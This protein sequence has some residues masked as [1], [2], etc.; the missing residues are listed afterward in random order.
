MATFNLNEDL[1]LDAIVSA[2]EEAGYQ[3]SDEQMAKIV[4]AIDE[5]FPGVIQVLT[6]GMQEQWKAEAKNSGTGWGQKYAN[7][8]KAKVTGTVGEIYI[9]E[10]MVDKSSHKPNMLFVKMVEE[11]MKSFSIKDALLA[12]DKAKI[13]SDG[14]RYITIPFPIAT[15]KTT[16]SKSASQF[17]GREMTKEMY[18]IVK[19]GGRL[20]SGNIKAGGKDLD[21]S[22]LTKYNT[23]QRHG[24]Y[25]I[26]RRVSETSSG[27]QHPGVA[28][29]P[30]FPSVKQAVDARIQEVL[31]EYCK[32]IVREFTS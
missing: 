25:G 15:P 24:Q 31:A 32:S 19:N 11:G 2:L 3:A 6:Y 28:R 30:V 9:D 26:F 27:W 4:D 1:I 18:N 22:G 16:E 29:S 12:S 14:I 10:N 20:T 8:I 13:G 21:V 5:S 23:R 17:G 7:A